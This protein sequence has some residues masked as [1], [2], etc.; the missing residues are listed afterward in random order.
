VAELLGEE[1]RG[2]DE[3]AAAEQAIVAVKRLRRAI[4]IP[5][6][7]SQL[8]GTAEQ[9]PGFAAKSLAIRR[10]MLLNPRLPSEADLLAI[11]Q[12]AF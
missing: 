7:I 10:L 5:E 1:T 2:L 3:S 11:L 9:L 4:G 12:A 6:R 8:G